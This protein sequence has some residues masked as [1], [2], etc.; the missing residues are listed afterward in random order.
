MGTQLTVISTFSGCGGSSLGYK[1]VGFKELL[2]IDF[3]HN[4]VETFKLNFP[5][6][7]VWERDISQVTAEEILSSCGLKRGQLDV[8]D[9]SP[10]CQ[11]FSMT[12]K[13][14]VSDKRNSLFE[15]FVRLVEGLKPKVFV[16][17]NVPGMAMG[18]MRG[19]YNVVMDRFEK[20]TYRVECK[21]M[22]AMN[23]GVP[24]SR[25]RLFWIGVDDV[26]GKNPVFPTPS[27]KVITVGQALEG[28]VDIGEV[29]T[30]T[31]RVDTLYNDIKPGQ[32]MDIIYLER[33]KKASYFNIRKL[34]LEKPSFTITKF[35][36]K[37][38]AG[39]L[40]PKEK[41]FMT[42]AELKRL[43]SFPD[44][45]VFTGKFSDQWARIGNAVMPKMMQAVAEV[46]KQE[47]LPR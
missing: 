4:S 30:P 28:L 27:N 17:E 40:H 13:R 7:P 46:I 34:S 45:F 37:E 8:F 39:L 11:G 26:L 36:S 25:R 15:E 23:Y 16:M 33:Y 47:I 44:D 1:I 21:M 43:A 14:K 22:N 9:G 3:D 35:F 32:G 10:P 38:M 2:A 6:V 31:G 18:K 5:D 20:T 29:V 24:Q 19:M 12:G 41:R 42:I